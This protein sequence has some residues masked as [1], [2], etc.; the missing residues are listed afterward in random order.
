MGEV[1]K[2]K[3]GE[4]EVLET[5]QGSYGNQGQKALMCNALCVCGKTF[6]AQYSHIKLGNTNSCGCYRSKN[7]SMR[8]YKHGHTCGGI[9]I[10]LLTPTYYCWSRFKSRCINSNDDRYHLYGG[11]GI[12]YCQE[13]DKFENFLKDMGEKPLNHRFN[14]IDKEGD[15][16]PDNC[17]WVPIKGKRRE[18]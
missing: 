11:R 13:W 9:G 5:W 15:F 14:R 3:A 8:L 4:I 6:R 10:K 2:T 17:E 18:K 7:N 16:E 1:I 12:K